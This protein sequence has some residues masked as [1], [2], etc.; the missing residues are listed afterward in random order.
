MQGAGRGLRIA[1]GAELSLIDFSDTTP[2][3]SGRVDGIRGRKR[4]RKKLEAVAPSRCGECG[5]QVRL[6]VRLNARLGS[7]RPSEPEPEEARAASNA[8]I[9]A[10]RY[11]RRSTYPI[12]RARYARHQKPGSPDSLRAEYWCGLRIAACEWVCLD[13]QVGFARAKAE[14][15][16]AQRNPTDSILFPAVLTR[17]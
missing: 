2:N 4:G 12:D 11:S 9:M 14:R 17:L 7:P 8:A 1:E 15:W 16:W 13:H 3:D 6:P 5:N 10:H